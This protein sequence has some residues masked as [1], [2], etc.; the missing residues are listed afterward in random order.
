ML[1]T[2]AQRNT[3]LLQHMRIADYR[4]HV[5]FNTCYMLN[6]EEEEVG[7]SCEMTTDF[8]GDDLDDLTA[9]VIASDPDFP[10]T[11]L[12]I[13]ERHEIDTN[14][15]GVFMSAD[16]DD[17]SYVVAIVVDTKVRS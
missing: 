8:V 14:V 5:S 6:G 15:V 11:F 1:L 16:D 17:F 3:G 7:E 12:P 9:E 13:T 10:M 2:S 4:Y